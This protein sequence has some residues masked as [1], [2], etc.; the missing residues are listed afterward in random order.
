MTVALGSTL[1]A[2]ILQESVAL[3][4]GTVALSVLILA[5]FAVTYVSVKS[6]TFASAVRSEP[7]LLVRDGRFCEAAM[8]RERITDA[9]ALG[10]VRAQGGRS[11]ENAESGSDGSMSV[12]LRA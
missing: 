7:A 9:E 6:S 8:R 11:V 2:I 12:S 10:A 3:A 4:E 1:S 5:Q